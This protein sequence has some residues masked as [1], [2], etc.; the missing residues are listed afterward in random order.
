MGAQPRFNH[1]QGATSAESAV[2]TCSAMDGFA[3]LGP[4]GVGGFLAA[5]LARAGQAVTVV[6]REQTAGAIERS[7]IAVRSAILGEFTARPAAVVTSLTERVE[8][9]FVT[10]KATSLVAALERIETAPDLIVPLLN[11]FEHLAVL[12]DR[13]GTE[14]IPAA[15]IRIESDAPQPGVVVQSSP[16][17]RIDVA[18]SDPVVAA[19]LPALVRSLESAGLKAHIGRSESHVMWSKLVRL[20][21][22]SATTTAAQQPLGYIR[23]DPAWRARLLACVEE[24]RPSRRRTAGR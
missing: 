3:V 11:G 5:A 15:V 24:E 14:R 9:L 20:S 6:A 21:A 16:V 18:A 13:F 4:G 12:R 8:V 1:F 7:G 10:T 22:L 2:R 19:R 23:T 17:A